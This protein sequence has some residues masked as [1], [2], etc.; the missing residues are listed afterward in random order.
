MQKIK[1][2]SIINGDAKIVLKKL[3]SNSV[4]L[5]VT[6]PPYSDRRKSSYGGIPTEKYV[7]WFL[8]ISD[9][10]KR[11][12]KPD[13]SFVINIKEGAN[14]QKETYVIE[15]I[16]A[17]KEQGWLWVE[18]YMWRKTTSMPGKWPNRFRDGW[19]R[20]LHFTKN[21]KFNMYQEEVMVPIGDWAKKRMS[22]LS[23]NDKKRT[24]SSTNSGF[25]RN[26]LMWKDREMVY[27]D[28]VLV[29]APICNNKGHSAVFPKELPMWF[30]K[31]FT[32]KGDMVLDPFIGSGTSAIASIELERKFLGIELHK[33]YYYLANKNIKEAIRK[34]II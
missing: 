31:L 25:G 2:N 19:E 9:Q 30:I 5:I 20:C 10:L 18:E 12:L 17:L 13:G 23:K 26:L 11:V 24:R 15:L 8:P 16:L 21:K 32:K 34:K 22:S 4:N 27:P 7:K 28:N 3:P 1:F 33:P 6:S 29:F 14:G